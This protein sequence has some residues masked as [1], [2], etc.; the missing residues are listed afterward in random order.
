LP[1]NSST[2]GVT[3]KVAQT[4]EYTLGS[5][6]VEL[7]DFRA[8]VDVSTP[9]H[10]DDCSDYTKEWYYDD[11]VNPRL[12]LPISYDGSGDPSF[13][14]S[15]Y[16]ARF[17][18]NTAS[19]ADIG[20]H[21]FHFKAYLTNDPR[22][23]WDE[24]VLTIEIVPACGVLTTITPDPTVAS[25]S[26]ETYA[27]GVDAPKTIF[28]TMNDAWLTNPS[29]VPCANEPF[30]HEYYHDDGVNGPVLLQSD[31]S[32]YPAF[33]IMDQSAPTITMDVDTVDPAHIGVHTFRVKTF[34]TNYPS[35]VWE[36]DFM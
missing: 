28:T 22:I 36:G 10:P 7:I 33:L 29:G 6:S 25:L 13:L 21:I 32:N 4:V 14:E 20:T 17:N 15:I 3:L 26:S 30:T 19:T 35:Y 18:V 24:I 27:M 1:R 8:T 31:G 34:L 16:G 12:L 9:P 2:A 5:G 11:G 23:I